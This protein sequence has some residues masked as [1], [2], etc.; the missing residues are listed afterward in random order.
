MCEGTA[1]LLYKV[2]V[3]FYIATAGLVGGTF[4]T[5]LLAETLQT[6]VVSVKILPWECECVSFHFSRCHHL[7]IC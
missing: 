4:N 6:S 7:S 5:S 1:R 3:P 2:V